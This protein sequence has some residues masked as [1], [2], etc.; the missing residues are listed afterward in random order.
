MGAACALI[1][2][3]GTTAC[4][5]TNTPISAAAPE[6]T[7]TSFEQSFDNHSSEA[8]NWCRAYFSLLDQGMTSDEIYRELE[9]NRVFVGAGGRE[10]FDALI[11]W[12]FAN[13]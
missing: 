2:L 10:A 3:G 12:C 5:Q 1:A 9:I 4:G 13:S 6:E 8:L 7:T 11:R